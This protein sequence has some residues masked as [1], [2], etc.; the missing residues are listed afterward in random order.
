MNA[1]ALAEAAL[2]DAFSVTEHCNH[3]VQCAQANLKEGDFAEALDCLRRAQDPASSIE[4][5]LR[6]AIRYVEQAAKD[7]EASV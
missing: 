1:K 5:R 4:Y 2:F 6:D 3:L 7:P